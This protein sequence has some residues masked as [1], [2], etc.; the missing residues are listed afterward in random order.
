V[1]LWARNFDGALDNVFELQDR[2]A[3]S[4]A[5]VVEPL[6]RQAEIERVRDLPVDPTDPYDLYVRA[7]AHGQTTRPGAAIRMM[8]AAKRC[9]DLSPDYAPALALAASGYLALFDQQMPGASEEARLA[10]LRHAHHALAV[11]GSD[12]EARG[13]AALSIITLGQEYDAG[14]AAARQ[15]VRDN[16]NSAAVLGYAG[17]ACLRAGEL[18]EAERYLLRA[19]DLDARDVINEWLLTGMAHSRLA[20]GKYADALQWGAR[21]YAIAPHNQITV[22]YITA[23]HAHLGQFEEARRWRAVLEEVAPGVTLA[24]IARGQ[25]M[26]DPHRLE[27]MLS[28]LRLAGVPEH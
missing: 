12:A 22:W 7:L 1:H 13:T 8:E 15:A 18:D 5:S 17:V 28:G 10:G 23:A 3:G 24:R 6:M 27:V 16:P 19:I 14:V 25:Q 26:R 11:A 9:L 2:V 21:S 20:Q 4:V